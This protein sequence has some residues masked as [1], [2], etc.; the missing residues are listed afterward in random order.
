M[1]ASLRRVWGYRTFSG[2]G[3]RSATRQNVRKGHGATN[4]ADPLLLKGG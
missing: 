2:A 4:D 1:G 3:K